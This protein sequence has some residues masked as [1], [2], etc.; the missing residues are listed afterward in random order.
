MPYRSEG[1]GLILI[2]DDMPKNL[3]LLGN[4]LR[5]EG[6]QVSAATSGKQALEILENSLPDL[7]LLDIMMP[8]LS[9]L[10]VCEILKKDAATRQIPI[11]FLT[12][13]TESEDV[14]MGFKVGGADYIHKPFNGAELLARVE[15]HVEIKKS[16]DF[17]E[18]LVKDLKSQTRELK[19]TNREM[20][21]FIQIVIHDLKNPIS[22]IISIAE[23]MSPAGAVGDSSKNL[24]DIIGNS[25]RMLLLIKNLLDVSSIESGNFVIEASEVNVKEIF[26]KVIDANL[27]SATA[28]A[29]SVHLICNEHLTLQ[30]DPRLLFEIIDNLLSNAIKYSYVNSDVLILV[31]KQDNMIYCRVEDRGVGIDESDLHNLFKKFARLSN[32]P[33]GGESSNGLGLFI[34]KLLVNKLKGEIWYEE[35]PTPGATFVFRIPL[36]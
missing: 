7:I 19:K 31:E 24:S 6:Y 11:I 32:Q 13:K 21:D 18:S 20:D 30:T 34:V 26:Q 28:K 23:D 15:T 35:K 1:K 3:Q 8:G 10:E 4:I 9:G 2:V 27:V 36:E 16:R 29:I 25:N 12:A 5:K 22:N 14:I 33:T 17:I